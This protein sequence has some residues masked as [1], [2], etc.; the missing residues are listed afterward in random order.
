MEETS[1]I[2]SVRRLEETFD[3]VD[4]ARDSS[5]DWALNSRLP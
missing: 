5:K 3:N 4:Q 1:D 2:P